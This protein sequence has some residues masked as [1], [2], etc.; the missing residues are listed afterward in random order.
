MRMKLSV[1]LFFILCKSLGFA[2][3]KE[4]NADRFQL[5]GNLIG[6]YQGYMYLISY[7]D[8]NIRLTDSSKILNGK[9]HFEGSVNCFSDRYYLKLDKEMRLNNDSVNSVNISL[10]NSI[11]KITLVYNHF[12]LFKMNGCTSCEELEKYENKKDEVE[13]NMEGGEVEFNKDEI[14]LM[15]KRYCELNPDSNI[16]PYLLYWLSRKIKMENYEEYKLLYNNLSGR[17]QKSFYGIKVKERIGENDTIVSST[18]TKA[19]DFS[20]VDL[21]GKIIHLN[22]IYKENYVLLDFWASW[23]IP[24]RAES[25]YLRYLY[26]MYHSKGFE[27]IS[28]SSDSN[29][30]DWKKAIYSDSIQNWKHILLDSSSIKKWKGIDGSTYDEY[31]IQFLPTKILINKNG[32]II[33]RYE[34]SDENLLEKKLS[35]IFSTNIE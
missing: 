17:Q 14:I 16:S 10:D 4:L 15:D 30:D 12:S 20:S 3:N 23:C 27:L 9:F 7:S 8:E 31:H 29:V 1:L 34:S 18:S 13:K 5:N 6:N 28:I 26:S 33:G 19:P 24:C 2:K 32:E 25:K 11:I 21:N 22:S 35:E